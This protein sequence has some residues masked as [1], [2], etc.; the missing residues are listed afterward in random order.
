MMPRAPTNWLPPNAR[1]ALM[2][3]RS[4]ARPIKAMAFSS[5]TTDTMR[6]IQ[7]IE[8][9]TTKSTA[10][11]ATPTSLPRPNCIM[12]A[13]ESSRSASICEWHV[14][15]QWN[16]VEAE[17]PNAGV[18]HSVGAECHHC[19]D[20]CSSQDVVPVVE[21]VNCESTS[22]ECG[23][24]DWHVGDDELPVGRVVVGPDFELSIEVEIEEDEA[25]ESS[26]SMTGG[27]RFQGV[28]DLVLV[29]SANGAVVHYIA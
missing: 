3:A 12:E 4:S 20:D 15:H 21:L 6:S 25:T 19:S 10:F 5:N 16:V 8:W 17:V 1:T 24:E 14:S 2:A 13:I 11:V 23:G 18:H 27:E 7:C 29:A 28:V 22:N 9:S 26:C